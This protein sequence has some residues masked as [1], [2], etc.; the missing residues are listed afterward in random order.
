MLSEDGTLV[1]SVKDEAGN[2][3]KVDIQL[4]VVKGS[5][6]ITL[7]TSEMNIFGGVQVNVS[8]NQLIL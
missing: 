6:Q 7:K 1:M 2:V 4:D 8:D 3:R 5:P